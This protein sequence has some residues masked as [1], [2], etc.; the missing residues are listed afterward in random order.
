MITQTEWESAQSGDIEVRNRILLE[1]QGL[2]EFCAS[3][4]SKGM[5]A[6][7]DKGDLISSGQFGLID[8]ISRFDC[9]RGLQFETFAV[10]RIKG[11][12]LDELRSQD[13]VPRSVRSRQRNVT[14]A[15][16]S[17]SQEMGG[18][19]SIE[20]V[21]K[22]TDLSRADIAR[23]ESNSEFGQIHT[24]DLQLSDPR[25]NSG[26]SVSLADTL[27]ND[28]GDL[29]SM[30]ENLDPDDMVEA[31]SGLDDRE[32]MVVTMHYYLGKSLAE[33]GREFG[34]TESRVCQIHTKALKTIRE[35][36]K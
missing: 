19:A 13:W 3:S 29:G 36:L 6:H 35:G 15:I 21:I 18:S 34:V 8:A 1:F 14:K 26:G 4:L 28:L 25:G 12:I 7:I 11:A 32:V 27:T 9:T 30:F 17:V 31:M 16:E 20:E 22:R 10:Q 2:V 24:L 23:A 5:P 33:I